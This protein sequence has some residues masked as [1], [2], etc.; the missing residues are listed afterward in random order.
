MRILVHGEGG[1]QGMALVRR[2]RAEGEAVRAY[3]RDAGRAAALA[4][5]GAAA[6]GVILTPLERWA[7]A[8]LR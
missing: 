4:G 3:S 5:L 6:A 1:A 8:A 7:E 2:L